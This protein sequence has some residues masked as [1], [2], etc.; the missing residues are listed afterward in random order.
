MWLFQAK[1]MSNKSEKKL[2]VMT[3]Y[4]QSCLHIAIAGAFHLEVD[5]ES[6]L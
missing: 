3:G 6:N 4:C 2:K 5:F 1:H